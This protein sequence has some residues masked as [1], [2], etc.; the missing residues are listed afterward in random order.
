MG[1]STPP[2]EMSPTG[3]LLGGNER[4]L[5]VPRYLSALRRGAWLMVFIIVPLTMTVL[6]VSLILPKSYS[7]TASLVLDERSG[8]IDTTGGDTSVRRLATIQRLLTSRTTLERAAAQLPG[9]TADTL[10]DKVNVTTDDAADIIRG[11][12][13]DSD[14]AGAA[15]I[16]NSVARTFLADQRAADARSAAAERRGLETL[17]GQLQRN[18]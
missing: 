13:S 7:A 10:A 1:E 15:A 4:A 8:V 14:A 9:E 2:G 3:S 12:G 16:A 11:E 5:D 6:I 17:L 18:G